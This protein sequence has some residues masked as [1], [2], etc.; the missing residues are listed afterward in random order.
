MIS[1]LF[2]V[3]GYRKLYVVVCPF[4]YFDSHM[5]HVMHAEV[6]FMQFSWGHLHHL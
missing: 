3:C 1:S 4:F 6:Y 5:R 2:Y